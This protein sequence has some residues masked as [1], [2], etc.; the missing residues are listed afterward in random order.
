MIKVELEAKVDASQDEINF[1]R[2]V[3]AEVR[4]GHTSCTGSHPK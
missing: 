3:Y 1:L 4:D 2:V